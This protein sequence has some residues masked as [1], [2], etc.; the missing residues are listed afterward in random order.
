[1]P[2]KVRE[3]SLNTRTAR[4]KLSARVKPY[5]RRLNAGLHLGYYRPSTKG[6]PG[7]WIGRRYLGGQRY[8]TFDLGVADDHSDRPADGKAVLTFDQAQG[9]AE[10]WNRRQVAE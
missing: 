7:S 9:A 2:A 1:M 5:Y 10:E 4:V 6:T 8:R 3:V